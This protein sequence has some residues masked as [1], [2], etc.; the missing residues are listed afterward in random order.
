MNYGHSV[1]ATGT[2]VCLW[3]PSLDGNSVLPISVE[4]S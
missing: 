3:T 2:D 1:Y 4:V